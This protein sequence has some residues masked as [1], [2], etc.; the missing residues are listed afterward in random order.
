M[1]IGIIIASVFVGGLFLLCSGSLILSYYRRKARRRMRKNSDRSLISK[2]QS[3]DTSFQQI[4]CP[5]CQH[6]D[7][8]QELRE[9]TRSGRPTILK[10]ASPEALAQFDMSI[11]NEQPSSMPGTAPPPGFETGNPS[12]K[13]GSGSTTTTTL[14]H[15]PLNRANSSHLQARSNG[16]GARKT[17]GSGSRKTGGSGSRKSGS[18]ALKKHVSG[19]VLLNNADY[20]ASANMAYIQSNQQAAA[21]PPR[22]PYPHYMETES[23][24]NVPYNP[25][26][27]PPPGL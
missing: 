26:M 27:M 9:R 14:S 24:Q 8:E 13:Y 22:E 7:N 15:P 21:P 18:A 17:G 5:L 10:S 12:R 23:E 19:K 2:S 20:N 11:V 25:P 16:S 1:L 6:Q 4:C 3:A